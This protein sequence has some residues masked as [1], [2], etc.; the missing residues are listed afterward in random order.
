MDNLAYFCGLQLSLIVKIIFH[1]GTPRFLLLTF[2]PFRTQR[3]IKSWKEKFLK[4]FLETCRQIPEVE[5]CFKSSDAVDD[6]DPKNKSVFSPEDVGRLAR[7]V[8][9]LYFE[10]SGDLECHGGLSDRYYDWETNL[11]FD[12]FGQGSYEVTRNFGPIH[13]VS[14]FRAWWKLFKRNVREIAAQMGRMRFRVLDG[15]YVEL[16]VLSEE[17]EYEEDFIEVTHWDPAIYAQ[18]FLK[19]I[20]A[21]WRKK[22]NSLR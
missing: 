13:D 20:F 18:E 6:F 8:I 19:R 15:R 11:R 22:A 5:D 12:F 9:N 21:E 14:E 3:D 2:G 16:E 7:Q 17:E 10:H 1:T 4:E